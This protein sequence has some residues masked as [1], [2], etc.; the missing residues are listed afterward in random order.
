MG[1]GRD[2]SYYLID[3]LYSSRIDTDKVVHW[4][5]AKQKEYGKFFSFANCDNARPEQNEVLRRRTNLI[6]HEEKPKVE[7][8]IAQVR[9]LI[10]Y[11]RVIVSDRCERTLNEFSLYR[12]PNNSDDVPLKINDDCM[13]AL[14]Y[15]IY[16][17]IALYKVSY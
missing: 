9:S 2:G 12:Y 10:N 5:E 14:R 4:I 1:Y 3:E 8:S 7:D 15:A 11:D 16:E 6:I 17:H 13:D